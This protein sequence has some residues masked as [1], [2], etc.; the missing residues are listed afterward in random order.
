VAESSA[1]LDA[2]EKSRPESGRHIK[3]KVYW[4]RI[5]RYWKSQNIVVLANSQRLIVKTSE[6]QFG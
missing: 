5:K 1:A 2:K 3:Q 4:A 6:K